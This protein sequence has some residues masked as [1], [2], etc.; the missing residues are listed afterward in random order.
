[1]SNKKLLILDLDETL[2]HATKEPTTEDWSFELSQYKVYKRPHLDQFL[3]EIEEH[4]R[5]SVWS[6]AS[7]DYVEKVVEL[8]F[9]KDYPLVFVWGRSKCT[10]QFD[11]QSINDLGYSDYY[12]HLNFAKILKKIKTRGIAKLEETLIVDDTPRK[13]KYNY[14]N[15]IYPSE[16]NGNKNDEE[17]KF[18]LTYLISIKNESNFR[19]IEKR[20]WREQMK[21]GENK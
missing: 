10:Q 20:N 1:M 21:K 5:I 3:R 2:I 7:D 11:H 9:P 16:F 13:S 12:N 17:L 6:S 18:L 4:Y 8:I 14:G 19:T 15:A